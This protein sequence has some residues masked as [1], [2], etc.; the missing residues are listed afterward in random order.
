MKSKTK[1]IITTVMSF[2]SALWIVSVFLF[3]VFRMDHFAQIV[4]VLMFVL[5]FLF[6]P[7]FALLIVIDCFYHSTFSEHHKHTDVILYEL[8]TVLAATFG[9][10][11]MTVLV[12]VG[13]K[14]CFLTILN[15]GFNSSLFGSDL[16]L[17]DKSTQTFHLI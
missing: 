13:F 9:A 16:K 14:G 8:T 1:K 2:A 11:S 4:L 10:A 5:P 6:P 7:L 3:F 17:P 12:T 15:M